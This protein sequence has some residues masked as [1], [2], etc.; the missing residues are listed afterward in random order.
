MTENL[1]EP[2]KRFIEVVAAALEEVSVG[3]SGVAADRWAQDAALE[4][5]NLVCGLVGIDRPRV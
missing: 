2:T 4:A 3:V 1:V 5:F